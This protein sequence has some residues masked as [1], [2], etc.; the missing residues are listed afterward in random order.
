RYATVIERAKQLV[1]LAQQVESAY[2]SALEK[3][4]AESYG[5]LKARQ[6]MQ[7]AVAGVR[8][9]DLKVH[10]AREGATLAQ[11]QQR[12][13]GIQ[14]DHYAELLNQ[15]ETPLEVKSL[16][17]LSQAADWQNKV[18]QGAEIAQYFPTFGVGASAAGP[19]VSITLPLDPSKISAASSSQ[20][21]AASSA[22]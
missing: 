18:A 3:R 9:Q 8:L 21:T 2:L 22:A 19:S 20:A 6:D 10:E 1:G 7:L 5:L 15:G 14:V 12:R 17:L 16:D 4:D 13:V 11:L